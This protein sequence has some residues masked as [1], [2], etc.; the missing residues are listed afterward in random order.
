MLLPEMAITKK[1][2]YLLISREGFEEDLI[3]NG[4]YTDKIDKIIAIMRELKERV[5]DYC[6]D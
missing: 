6:R 1:G 4:L 3:T 5:P 2:K